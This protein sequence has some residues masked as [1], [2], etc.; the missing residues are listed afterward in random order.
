[1]STNCRTRTLLL[2]ACLAILAPLTAAQ[3]FPNGGFEDGFR[4]CIGAFRALF[5]QRPH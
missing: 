1:M 2:A 3:G 5:G 4:Q